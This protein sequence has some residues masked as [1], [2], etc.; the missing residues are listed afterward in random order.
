MLRMLGKRQQELLGCL[1][2]HKGGLAVDGLARQLGITR[3][4]VRQHLTALGVDGLVA[5][6]AIRP[7]GGR[8]EQLYVLTEAGR[9]V[10]PRHYSWFAQLMVESISKE[11][12][13]AGLRERMA[14][15]GAEVGQKLRRQQ[16][17]PDD[18]RPQVARLAGLMEQLGYE[19]RAVGPAGEEAEI[20]ADN[21]IFHNLAA[22]HPEICQFDLA[23]L[24]TF[25]DR[26]VDHQ[27]CMVRGGHVCRFRFAAHGDAAEKK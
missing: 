22:K 12:G 5:P 6:D 20:V 9:E 11:S 21:C 24:A 8:P 17:E 26:K 13:A 3:N 19:A 2:Q 1:R 4:A 16:H 23:L 14:A 27:E 25:T 15:M 10:F 18:S 7:S